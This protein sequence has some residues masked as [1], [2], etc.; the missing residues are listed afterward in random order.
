MFS[1]RHC[2]W[3][4]PQH[5]HTL[6]LLFS[7]QPKIPNP[8]W[9]FS[10]LSYHW[11]CW[12]CENMHVCVG[13][14]LHR[15]VF[16]HSLFYFFMMSQSFYGH[17][18]FWGAPPYRSLSFFMY[19]YCSWSLLLITPYINSLTFPSLT[20]PQHTHILSLFPIDHFIFLGTP[21]SLWLHHLL[22]TWMLYSN[23]LS[24]VMVDH[25]SAV[26]LVG[27]LCV[28]NLENERERARDCWLFSH[29]RACLGRVREDITCTKMIITMLIPNIVFLFKTLWKNFS[30]L[31]LSTW[32]RPR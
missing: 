1:R 21:T 27:L 9:W 23:S 29:V 20:R 8:L 19:I 28:R 31:K 24:K 17:L 12:V 25:L 22:R 32:E 6:S 30:F 5:T 2:I 3:V 14:T 18:C 4:T 13:N 7:Y 10:K 16:L 11:K 15:T 26:C